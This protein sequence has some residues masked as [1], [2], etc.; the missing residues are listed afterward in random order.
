MIDKA[1]NSQTG[2]KPPIPQWLKDIRQDIAVLADEKV[3]ITG[4]HYGAMLV[5]T[6]DDSPGGYI[7]VHLV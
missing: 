2:P 4:I 7:T 3:T 6:D 1:V 5:L